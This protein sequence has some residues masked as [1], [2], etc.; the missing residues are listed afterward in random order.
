MKKFDLNHSIALLDSA[1]DTLLSLLGRIPE[2]W[3]DCNE[4]VNTWS[5]KNVI[6]HLILADQ[7]NW[8]SRVKFILNGNADQTF[9]AFDRFAFKDIEREN[10]IISL[11]NSFRET[12]NNSLRELKQLDISTQQ[13][14]M[15]AIHPEFGEVKLSELIATWTVHD[16]T[17]FH[18]IGR[19]LAKQYEDAVGPWK[20]YLG[21][22]KK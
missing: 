3:G 1:P 15:T 22:M 10:S 2:E 6:A 18:Q 20:A 7:S 9:P 12:R 4:G 13:L 16:L 11:L 21:I 5:I 14:N 8:L 17:H 19:I